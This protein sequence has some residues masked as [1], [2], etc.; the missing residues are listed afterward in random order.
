MIKSLLF[1]CTEIQLSQPEN[2]QK[3]LVKAK[4][5]G[6]ARLGPPDMHFSLFFGA[7]KLEKASKRPFLPSKSRFKVSAPLSCFATPQMLYDLSAVKQ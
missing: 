3:R 7:N 6:K 5:P 1:A 2:R 4:R